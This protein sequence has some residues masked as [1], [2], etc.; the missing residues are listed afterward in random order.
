MKTK[1][2]TAKTKVRRDSALFDFINL[3]REQ[4]Y[5]PAKCYE[6]AATTFFISV[7]RVRA[8]YFTEKRRRAQL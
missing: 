3:N 8:I 5:T 4:G 1:T 7:D 6:L 2:K